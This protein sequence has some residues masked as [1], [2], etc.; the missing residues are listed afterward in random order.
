MA[1]GGQGERAVAGALLLDRRLEDEPGRRLESEVP[2]RRERPER[3]DGPAFHVAGATAV[4]PRLSVLFVFDHARLERWRGPERD[5]LGAHHVDVPVE[6]EASSRAR[7]GVVDGHDVVLSVHR[8]VDRTES[9]QVLDRP[10]VDRLE[11]G[12]ETERREDLR[13]ASLT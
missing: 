9:G 4:H 12:R 6:R 5:R 3:R 7:A 2:K 13:D 8:P 10:E 11:N 1:V